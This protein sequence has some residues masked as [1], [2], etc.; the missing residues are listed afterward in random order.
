MSVKK[1]IKHCI[2]RAVYG[3]KA[4]PEEYYRFLTSIGMRIG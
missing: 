2:L 3:A 1:F 4:S